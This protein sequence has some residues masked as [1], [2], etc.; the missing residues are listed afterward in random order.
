MM[1]AIAS[2][3]ATALLLVPTGVQ[4]RCLAPICSSA[5]DGYDNGDAD[6]T[7]IDTA[8]IEFDRRELMSDRPA[9]PEQLAQHLPDWA[10]TMTLDPDEKEE[11]ESS[12]AR[13]RAKQLHAQRVDGREWE[14]LEGAADG[15]GAGFSEF[16]P[17]EVAEDYNLPLETVVQSLLSL[18]V[19]AKRLDVRRP[20]KAVCTAQQLAELL[21]FVGSADPIACREE[22]CENTL[23]EIAETE[24]PELTADQLLALCLQNDINPI[25]GVDTRLKAEEYTILIERAEYELAF[26]GGREQGL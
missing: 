6:A 1:N 23:S 8:A 18:G 5:D 20:V 21:A 11:Y 4:L 25:L 10:K 2:V 22:L 15:E 16:T 3:V 17:E 14:A 26:S 24:L 19:E 13:L 12:Q 7:P 9:T